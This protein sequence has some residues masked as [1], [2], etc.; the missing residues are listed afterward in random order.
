M[1]LPRLSRRGPQRRTAKDPAALRIRGRGLWATGGARA[2]PVAKLAADTARG[3]LRTI[4]NKMANLTA[5][6]A[7]GPFGAIYSTMAE[8]AAIAA[9]HNLGLTLLCPMALCAASKTNIVGSFALAWLL[10]DGG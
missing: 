7:P 5:S 2:G 9:T 4:C 8:L 1:S 3:R 6:M 10:R